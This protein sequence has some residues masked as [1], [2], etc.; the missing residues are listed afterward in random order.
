MLPSTYRKF[1]TREFFTTKSIPLIKLTK[2]HLGSVQGEV[3]LSLDF[4]ETCLLILFVVGGVI[5]W[6]GKVEFFPRTLFVCF[7]CPLNGRRR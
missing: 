7:R 4:L 5:C 6:H 3:L 2:L 1:E